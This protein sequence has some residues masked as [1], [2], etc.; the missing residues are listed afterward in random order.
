MRAANQSSGL[1]WYRTYTC[2]RIGIFLIINQGGFLRLNWLAFQK[3][4]KLLVNAN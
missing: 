1:D 3:S 2:S 4:G